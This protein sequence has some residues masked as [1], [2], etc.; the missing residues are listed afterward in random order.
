M[1]AKRKKTITYKDSGVDIDANDVM[2]DLIKPLVRSTY[3]PRVFGKHGGFAGLFRLD[4]DKSRFKRNYRQPVLVGCTD[5]VGSKILIARDCGRYDTVGIDLVAMNVNDMLTLGAEPLFFLDYVAVNKLLPKRVAEIV[6]GVAAGCRDA[7]CSLIGG[8]TAELPDIYKPDDFDLAGFAVGVV[9]KSQIIDGSQ[10]EAGD[11]IIGLP[12]SG[13]HSNGYALVRRLIFKEAGLKHNSVVP[14]ISGR[15]GDEILRPTR[16]YV[17]QV[18]DLL[19]NPRRRRAVRGM[20][21]ITGGGLV[22]NIDRVFPK[23]LKAVIDTKSWTVPPV[24][25]YLQ[26]LGVKRD[27]MFRVFN[28]GIGYVLMVKR[29]AADAVISHFRRRHQL[30]ALIIGKIEKGTTTVELA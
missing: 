13:L 3:G 5:G 22:G 1:M 2:V 29:T 30:D 20:S 14:A 10:I 25:R 15:I 18:L 8:E 12:S 24:F 9:E 16:I 23:G 7:K 4:T 21:H 28:M 27:E 6:A 19:N 26:T 17:R 11:V